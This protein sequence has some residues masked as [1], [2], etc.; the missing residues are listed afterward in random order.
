MSFKG[1]NGMSAVRN[2]KSTSSHSCG[3]HSRRLSA[4]NGRLGNG[5]TTPETAIRGATRYISDVSGGNV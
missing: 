3:Q 5:I 4:F 2:E 1:G